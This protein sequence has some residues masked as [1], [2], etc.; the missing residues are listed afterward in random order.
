MEVTIV[1]D[2]MRK[3][4]HD[5]RITVL[6]AMYKVRVLVLK[7]KSIRN[8]RSFKTLSLQEC[9]TCNLSKHADKIP[10]QC[11]IISNNTCL[12]YFLYCKNVS[13]K[14]NEW[15]TNEESLGCYDIA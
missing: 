15:Q 2:V 3:Y 11:C 5:E 9:S 13:C 14:H 4:V 12:L 8:C 10:L 1:G 6:S 7:A